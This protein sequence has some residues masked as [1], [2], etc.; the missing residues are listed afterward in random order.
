MPYFKRLHY[1]AWVLGLITVA[2]SPLQ[3][4]TLPQG[5]LAL[6]QEQGQVLWLN[7]ANSKQAELLTFNGQT[8]ALEQQ[9][10][11]TVGANQL[12][13]GF[14]PDG[15]KV[16]LLEPK[17][18]SILHRTGKS[19]RT[20]AVPE[21]PIPTSAYRPAAAITNATGTAQLFY[22][23]SSQQLQVIHTG[24]GKLLASVDLPKGKVL[25]LGLDDTMNRIAY[26]MAGAGAKADLYIYDLFKKAAVRTLG[27]PAPS[28]ALSQPVVFSKDSQYVALLPQLIDLKSG[29][30]T[31]LNDALGLAVFTSDK[32]SLLF[33]SSQGVQRF[34]LQTKQQSLTSNKANH[35]RVPVVVDVSA[36]NQRIAF[37]AL[38]NDP[39]NW[40][41]LAFF[42]AKTGQ[43]QRNLPLAK[44]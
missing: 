5:Y 14:T 17:G 20:L 23:A 9:V 19:L 7:A 30:S 18:L 39:K 41:A 34:D 28:Q 10:P 44:P 4:E 42:D 37:G 31:Q 25:A 36:D 40:A 3:A 15:F 12:V 35:C 22:L 13:M 33:A 11:L 32:Q 43:W 1:L 2:N 24:N 16:A 27:I 29:E 6:S 21:L 38:C 26:V 8:G